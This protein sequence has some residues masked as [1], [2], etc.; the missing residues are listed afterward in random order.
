MCLCSWPT[1]KQGRCGKRNF[2]LYLSKKYLATVHSTVCPFS[3]CSGNLINRDEV[4]ISGCISAPDMIYIYHFE[5]Y[6]RL[7]L[8]WFTCNIAHSIFSLH[9]SAVSYL[10]LETLYF[11]G[12]FHSL[13]IRQWLPLL[14]DIS[15][16]QHLAHKFYDRLCFVE[17]GGR[18][19]MNKRKQVSDKRSQNT[20]ANRTFLRLPSIFNII[21]HCD[22]LTD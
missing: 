15:Y 14:I 6:L 19:W 3:S 16:I 11:F 12:K 17:G 10:D 1:C 4:Y 21:F 5:M 18:N 20:S 2:I 13:R 22:G 8:G 7:H 9:S